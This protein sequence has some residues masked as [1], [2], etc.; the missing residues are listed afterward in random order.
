MLG[1][2][3]SVIEEPFI[4]DFSEFRQFVV[5]QF[6]APVGVGCDEF[7]IAGIGLFRIIGGFNDFQSE[8]IGL[9]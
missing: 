9:F 3:L 4:L 2:E 1:N 6:Y 5:F 8:P 7:H